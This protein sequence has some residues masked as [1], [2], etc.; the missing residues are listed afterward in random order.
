MNVFS[1]NMFFAAIIAALVPGAACAMQYAPQPQYGPP[2]GPQG[3]QNQQP[4]G[5]QQPYMPQQYVPQYAPQY[6]PQQGVPQGMPQQGALSEQQQM[7][8]EF[9]QIA[10]NPQALKDFLEL[11]MGYKG[12]QLNQM[13]P[14]CTNNALALMQ[15]FQQR[16]Q[17]L[18]QQPQQQQPVQQS[19]QPMPQQFQQPQLT[20]DFM[21]KAPRKALPWKVRRGAEWVCTTAEMQGH[22]EAAARDFKNYLWWFRAVRW[23]AY[24][25]GAGA[26]ALAA[27][28]MFRQWVPATDNSTQALRDELTQLHERLATLEGTSQPSTGASSWLAGFGSS[29][30]TMAWGWSSKLVTDCVTDLVFNK[31]LSVPLKY[32][33]KQF[34]FSDIVSSTPSLQWFVTNRT[35]FDVC[36]R[37]VNSKLGD[38]ANQ[39]NMW[40]G[41][42][43]KRKEAKT[44]MDS[45]DKEITAQEKIVTDLTAIQNRTVQQNN[46]L[47]EATRK[48]SYKKTQRDGFKTKFENFNVA[49]QGIL[50]IYV[51]RCT[52]LLAALQRLFKESEK[53]LGYMLCNKEENDGDSNMQQMYI[54]HTQKISQC[55]VDVMREYNQ[56]DIDSLKETIKALVDA[57]VPPVDL[58]QGGGFL[59]MGKSLVQSLLPQGVPGYQGVLG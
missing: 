34:P 11:D 7:M 35:Q 24:G 46:R 5:L 39:M 1:R 54:D 28:H 17:Q 29:V 18:Q 2:Y 56:G 32:A 44:H 37:A 6:G 52:D 26:V 57:V 4:Y 20:P 14:K 49:S 45:L 25:L 8:V 42:Y 22:V 23:P 43:E 15:V 3:F 13:I 38:M 27:Y 59:D 58:Q 48:V 36:V 16:R 33:Q 31:I 51:L 19:Q 50:N 9:T 47:T 10:G 30:A 12:N 21:V 55:L 40:V 41:F 53:V